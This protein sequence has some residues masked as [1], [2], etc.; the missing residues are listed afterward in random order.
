[1]IAVITGDII[2]SQQT[3]TELWLTDLKNLLKNWGEAPQTWEI[4][5]GDEFQMK[6]EIDD[7]FRYFLAIKSLIKTY[8]NLDV[9]IAIG[10]GEE[11]FLSEKI[12]ESNGTAYVNSG[13]LLNELKLQGRTLAIKTP[14]EKIDRDLNIVFRWCSVDFDNW[15]VAVAEIIHQFIMNSDITQEDLARK[16]NITQSSVSQRSKR[17]NLDLIKETDLYFRKKI[18]EL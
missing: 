1:M 18:V 11:Q 2:N 15:T 13:R 6:C 8:E 14:D 7:V 17:A 9:R 3:E 12:T 16:L 10:I 4:Y 5:R